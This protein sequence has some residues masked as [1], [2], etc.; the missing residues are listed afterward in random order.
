MEKL[1]YVRF[2][3]SGH[4]GSA[5]PTIS[6]EKCEPFSLKEILKAYKG[7]SCTSWAMG[8]AKKSELESVYKEYG[9]FG[10]FNSVYVFSKN[11]TEL[12][13]EMYELMEDDFNGPSWENNTEKSDY[14]DYLGYIF[15]KKLSD[16][17]LFSYDFYVS[18]YTQ[19]LEEMTCGKDSDIVDMLVNV[20][21]GTGNK[22]IIN[23]LASN[24][25]ILYEKLSSILGKGAKEMG[26]L[27]N[28]GF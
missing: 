9:D 20:I 26:D 13:D 3:P 19:D 14:D 2:L 24:T 18:A 5:E 25:P 10:C 28:L 12:E 11:S 4:Y 22:K 1:V 16:N 23:N 8:D 7:A 21:K 27:G 6:D 15:S 17:Y